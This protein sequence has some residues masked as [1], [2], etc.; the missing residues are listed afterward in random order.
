M[1]KLTKVVAGAIL[2]SVL[3]CGAGAAHADE[4]GAR[5]ALTAAFDRAEREAREAPRLA[6][7]ET[8]AEK[9]VVVAGRFDPS[10]PP[11]GQWTPV[12][13]VTASAQQRDSYRGIVA[14]TPNER[15]LFLDRIR[16]SLG[17]GGRL[18]SESD[19]LAAFD[20]AMSPTARPTNSPLDGA[21]NLAAHIRVELVVNESTQRLASMRFYAPQAFS[22]TPLARVDRIDLRFTFGESYSGGPTVVRRIDTDAAYRVAG[23]AAGMRDTVWFGD[24]APAARASG[25]VLASD[26]VRN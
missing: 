25:V 19:G 23:I 5:A 16:A 8:V 18:V 13:V 24:V 12:G 2:A 26:R 6:F 7:T 22:A 1:P 14:D 21:L 3:A 9:G 10:R 15:D 4:P 20:F 11:G 17:D